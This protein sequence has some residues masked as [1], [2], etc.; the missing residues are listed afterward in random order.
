MKN[1]LSIL[2]LCAASAGNAQSYNDSIAQFRQHYKEDFLTD[3]HSPLKAADTGYLRFYVPDASYK[4]VAK[5]M[6]TPDAKPFEIA[7]H[8]GKTK[9]Y[10]KYGELSFRIHDTDTKLAVYQSIT[11][12]KDPKY[13]DYLFIP[14][15]DMSNYITTYAG[16]RYIDLVTGDIKSGTV[17]LDFNKCYNPYCAFAGGYS[18]PIP[19]DENKLKVF[20]A[21]GEKV[22]GKEVKE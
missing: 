8:S 15:N 11:L 7:T 12:M 22:F 18:C 20:I 4:I 13:K 10:R 14:F 17:V 2:L 5:F 9:T 21:A 3:G 1:I 19:P 16:G 6:A